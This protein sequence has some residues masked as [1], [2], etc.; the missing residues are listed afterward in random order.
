MPPVTDANLISKYAKVCRANIMGSDLTML[1]CGVS[2]RVESM[3]CWVGL[4]PVNN[5]S[6]NWTVT[7]DVQLCGSRCECSLG[8]QQPTNQ[9]M[10]KFV[11]YDKP[12]YFSNVDPALLDS[13]RRLHSAYVR[14][15]PCG[16]RVS[17]ILSSSVTAVTATFQQRLKTAVREH[18]SSHL[19]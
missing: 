1:V 16:P 9:S 7:M 17:N 2:T 12:F 11:M 13:R 14:H 15:V 3:S 18:S 8:S 4:G 19:L 5:V 6:G 10:V